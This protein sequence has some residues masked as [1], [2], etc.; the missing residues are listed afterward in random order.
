M[1][2]CLIPIPTLSI[3]DGALVGVMFFP[4]V[5]AAYLV[6]VW[7]SSWLRGRWRWMDGENEGAE[8]GHA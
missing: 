2:L 6:V 7:R 5:E 1:S 8:G 4:L 3:A